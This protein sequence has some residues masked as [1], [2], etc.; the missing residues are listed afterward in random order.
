MFK[1]NYMIS[2]ITLGT[3]EKWYEELKGEFMFYVN[4]K[5]GEAQIKLSLSRLEAMLIRVKL[6]KY[7]LTHPCVLKLTKCK[8]KRFR[9]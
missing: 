3:A 6:I 2:G 5:T 7:N 9:V 1:S 4:K 8:G